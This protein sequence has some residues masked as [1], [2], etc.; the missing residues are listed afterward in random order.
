MLGKGAKTNISY[1]NRKRLATLFALLLLVTTALGMV[2]NT[3]NA[4]NIARFAL[5]SSVATI[6]PTDLR[7]QP[8][9]TGDS[10]AKLP[11]NAK[12]TVLGGPFN[13]GWYWVSYNATTG[14]LDGSKLVLVDANWKPVD[15]TTPT[16]V[17]SATSVATTSPTAGST[18]GSTP[19]T[20]P[21]PSVSGDYT[22]LWLAEMAVGGNVRVG[23][24]LDQK[25]LK[26]WGAGR[27]VLLYQSAVDSKGGLWYRVS[28]PPEDPQ[29]VHSS[30]IT[31]VA[32]VQFDGPKFQGRWVGVNLTQQIATAYQDGT[33]VKV[34]LASTGTVRTL[35]NGT[36]EDLRT[37]VGTW[38][39][40]WRLP[41]QEM[42][43]GTIENGDYYDLKDVPFVQYFYQSGEALHGT[44]WHDDFGHPHSHGCV[45][46]STPMSEWFYG[47][48]NLGTTVYVHN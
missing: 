22:G 30:L 29:W 10:L 5:R 7:E 17:A 28:D 42:K 21:T 36:K 38:K 35:P 43:G 9:A 11:V 13:E 41:T 44:Y 45:N 4:Q 34:T 15:N 20:I 6:E 3:A 25:V 48:A 46:L 2:G 39:I 8:S 19:G 47:F 37:N 32:P 26:G 31:K 24:G 16:P 33:P 40:Y 27:R 18:P 23:P 1:R 14:Y 12:S